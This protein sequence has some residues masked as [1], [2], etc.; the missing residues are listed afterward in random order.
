MTILNRRKK[1]KTKTIITSHQKTA[2]I[3]PKLL[4]PGSQVSVDT[5]SA[6]CE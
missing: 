3:K 6:P 5:N 1:N 2:S 4:P